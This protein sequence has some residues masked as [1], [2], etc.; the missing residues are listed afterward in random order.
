MVLEVL[1][2]SLG[3]FLGLMGEQWR[4]DAQHR[5]LAQKSLRRFRA[6]I[7]ANRAAITRVEDY[8][9]RLHRE[10]TAYLESDQ[11]KTPATYDVQM[12][13]IQPVYFEDS[14]WNVALATQSLAYI[15]SELVFALSRIYRGQQ[16]YTDVTAAITEST[17]Y[18]RS[19]TADVEGF[20][21]SLTFYLGDV[22][23]MEPALLRMYE[24]VLPQIDRALGEASPKNT[25]GK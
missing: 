12:E 18:G 21:R 8:H 15:D 4:E 23:L 24:E 7:Q 1:L 6:E 10:L 17:L 20:A 2:I 19:L 22:V 14:A 13:G 25:A 16:A 5:E 11:P 3:V 9:V